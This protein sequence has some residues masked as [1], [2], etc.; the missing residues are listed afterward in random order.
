MPVYQTPYTSDELYHFGI[1]GMKWGVRRFQNE[2]GTLTA[3]GKKRYGGE[4]MKSKYSDPKSRRKVMSKEDRKEIKDYENEVYKKTLK[5]L[6]NSEEYKKAYKAMTDSYK[7]LGDDW[8]PDDETPEGERFY[9]LEEEIY[10]KAYRESVKA[11]RK[12]YGKDIYDY[13]KA[14]SREASVRS[15]A[16]KIGG[17]VAAYGAY[18]YLKNRK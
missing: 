5:Q 1:K 12:E 11:V 4:A 13:Y 18:K 6:E 17:A 3:A 8:N 9:K 15:T 10:A 14:S 7:R 2:D 16:A